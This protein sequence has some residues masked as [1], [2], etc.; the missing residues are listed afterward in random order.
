[1]KSIFELK[2]KNTD[3]S[4]ANAGL[5][6]YRFQEVQSL[7]NIS[8]TSFP[9]GQ[10]TFRWTYG[11][12]KY[13][14]PN[15]TYMKV[16]VKLTN[17]AGAQIKNSDQIALSMNTVPQLF[18]SMQYKIADQM[19]S[20]I[21]E[22]LA[23]VD[24]L[25]NRMKKSGY[26]LNT[27][28]QATNQ[29]KSDFIDR[30][31]DLTS[32]GGQQRFDPIHYFISATDFYTAVDANTATDLIDYTQSGS[33]ATFTF[34]DVDSATNRLKL[35]DG[36]TGIGALRSTVKLGDTLVYDH[37][38][39]IDS[40]VITS[41]T[42]AGDA[43]ANGNTL[44]SIVIRRNNHELVDT[45]GGPP[46]I[47]ASTIDIL[48]FTRGSRDSEPHRSLQEM[49]LIWCPP[50]SVFDKQH[51]IPCAGTKHELTVTP[52]PD[53]VYQS[54]AI[55]SRTANKVPG[56]DYIFTV[57]DMRLYILTCDSNTVQDNFEFM[58]DLDEVQCQTQ[59]ILS[60]TQQHSIDVVGSCNGIA[61]A[62]QDEAATTSTL[63]PLSKF[64]IRD[65]LEQNLQ[66]F[67]IR[68]E[69]QV[70]QPDFDGELSLASNKDT[71][72]DLYNRTKIYDGGIFKECPESLE[73]WRSRGMYI[74]HP[75]PKT[76]SS[77]NT[78]VYTNTQFS[79]LTADQQNAIEN[80][81]LL[82]FQFYK[83]V[84]VLKVSQGRI[85]SVTPVDA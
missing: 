49:D 29:W 11:S 14:I 82:L 45:V 85:V 56:T 20:Q 68:Y 75:F 5:T 81:L 32:L 19:V 44:N 84:V 24:T 70:P 23:Q 73:E 39:E 6:N 28:G 33:T 83:K 12:N 17:N 42:S 64:K 2:T 48:G 38:G 31:L 7:K 65:D 22:N 27:I 37:N 36:V 59:Q 26:W 43:D 63:Y 62:F 8:G 13:W 30:E 60:T 18:Q 61:L 78:R 55:E 10:I 4:S 76:A 9:D 69:Y 57:E 25:K 71:L 3:L 54:H 53:Q 77:R 67:Y 41:I 34:T 46:T 79:S 15:K 16:T 52:Y 35:R 72:V 51:A 47:A 66:Q 40:G 21:T 74:Y 50:L 80:P 58:L 1:M